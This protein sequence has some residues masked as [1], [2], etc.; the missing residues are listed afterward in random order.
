MDDKFF[1]D[2]K[3]KIQSHFE[4]GGSHAFDHT[5]RV[6]NLAVRIAKKEKVDLGVI[7]AA[8]L[9]H[10]VAR[11]KCKESCHAEEGA[12]IAREI[13]LN[14]KFPKDKIDAVCHAIEVHRQSKGLKPK[15]KEAAIIQDADRLD[16]LGAIT[17]ARM[18]STGGKMN[19]P[20]YDSKTPIN[21]DLKKSE[22][23]STIHGFYAKILKLKPET[24][25]TKDAQGLAKA[26]YLFVKKYLDIFLK[27]WEGEL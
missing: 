21:K 17:I 20:I 2:L 10:D 16:A 3:E 14:T 27:E 22:L 25:H 15:T 13:L 5:Q 23:P 11:S 8:A 7:K 24:F 1:E 9:L 4:K 18:F 19:L 12:K 6:Y 26:R